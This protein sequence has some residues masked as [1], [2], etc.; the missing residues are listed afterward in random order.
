MSEAAAREREFRQHWAVPGSR[1]D[2]L[3]RV[4]KVALPS[5]VGVLIAFLA[6]APLDKQGDVSFI[7]DQ[8]KVDAPEGCGSIRAQWRTIVQRFEISAI[9]VQR[10]SECRSSTQRRWARLRCAGR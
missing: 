3:V 1:H 2:R 5:A 9:R 6:L 7:L 4:A 8:K 10:S